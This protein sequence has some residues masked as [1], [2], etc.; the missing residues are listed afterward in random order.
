M[1]SVIV[2]FSDFSTSKP[3]RITSFS[4]LSDFFT[5]EPV[6][7]EQCL[8]ENFGLLQSG[9]SQTLDCVTCTSFTFPSILTTFS[10]SLDSMCCIF[11]T[12][13]LNFLRKNSGSSF[14]T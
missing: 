6:C 4:L 7:T 10:L 9:Y 1:S 2:T 13:G 11:D 8:L 3:E 5:F 14:G 12:D